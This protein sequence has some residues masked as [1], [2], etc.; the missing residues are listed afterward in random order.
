MAVLLGNKEYFKN[1]PQI[2]YEGRESDNPLAFHWYDE[3]RVVAGKT[4][5][6]HFRFA[7]AYWHSFCN[8]G[9]DPFG[10][11]THLF[12]WN[13]QT[14]VVARAKDKMD[15]A[16]EFITKMNL[17]FY[18]FHDVDLVD[19]GT[20]IIENEQR[21]QALVDYARQKQ[22]TAALNYCGAPPTYFLI[23]VI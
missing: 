9:S 23:R 8:E 19:Y 13:R 17:P 6:E 7:C 3:N 11:G 21:L 4:L 20:N 10:P 22:K 12:E 2:K 5:K 1:I 15:A 18:C 16:F 14:D